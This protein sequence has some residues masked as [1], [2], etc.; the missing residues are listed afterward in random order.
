MN[1]LRLCFA[2]SVCVGTILSLDDDNELETDNVEEDDENF[3][4]DLILT[5]EQKSITDGRARNAMLAVKYKWPNG[6][7]PYR[8]N[9]DHFGPTQI[10]YIRKAMDTIESVSCVKFVEAKPNATKY[11]RIVSEKSGCSSHLGYRG[12]LQRLN[13]QSHFPG[14]GC[15][16]LGT[17]MHELL[18][19]LGFVHQQ[20][21][22]DRNDY[23]TISWDNIKPKHKHNFK[24]YDYYSVTD[25]DVKYDY[26]SILHYTPMAF[27]SNGMPTITPKDP[28]ARIG[29]RERLSE[30]DILKLNRMYKCKGYKQKPK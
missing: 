18:H 9:V 14:Q 29:Q 7:V 8:I 25:F 30:G 27:S 16:R 20:S 22:S 4:G 21:A 19:T 24:K 26:D 3:E 6:T 12:K 13:L 17:I 15:F 5:P 2:L 11:V 28:N 23:V 10:E 1:Y